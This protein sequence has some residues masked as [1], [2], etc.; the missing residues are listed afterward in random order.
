V[1][2]LKRYTRFCGIDIAKD[3]HVACILDRDGQFV[4]RSQSFTNDAEGYQRILTS[5][6]EAGGPSRVAVAMEATGHYWYSLHDFLAQHAYCLAVLNPIQSDQQAKKGIRKCQTD[7][8]DARHIATLLKN[9]DHKPALVPDDFAMT[10]RQLTR[11]RH[12]LVRQMARIKQLFW[13]RLHPVWPE[14]ETLFADAFAKTSRTLLAIAPTPTDLLALPQEELLECIRKTSRGR[15]GPEQA[16][17]IRRSA[18]TSIGT[19]R[20]IEAARIGI[21]SLLAQLDAL[22]PVRKQL[23][24]DILA[25]AGRL[26]TYLFTLPGADPLR[27]VSLFAETDPIHA[28]RSGSQLVAFAGL[29]LIVAES[30]QPKVLRRRISKRGSP[31]LRH[32]LWGMAHAAIKEKGSLRTYYLRR[33]RRGLHHLAAVTATALKLCHVAW[34]I[35]TDQRDY[36]PKPPAPKR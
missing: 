12:A 33:R 20:G 18:Q 15:F 36:M 5:L 2:P 32:T 26:P 34:R 24:E 7:R 11:L 4:V 6:Q 14:Y 13:S 31:F 35:L 28:F 27:A 10:C 22:R 9:G 17:K 1:T 16:E 30:G 21:R 19:R 29:D 25:L 23:E 3:K 8:I